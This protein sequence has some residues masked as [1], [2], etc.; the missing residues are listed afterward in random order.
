MNL[1]T[2]Q[3]QCPETGKRVH[4]CFQWAW[5]G[6]EYPIG[7]NHPAPSRFLSPSPLKLNDQSRVVGS[8]L[9]LTAELEAVE[10][11]VFVAR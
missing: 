3:C 11:D 10:I 6:L 9:E 5:E 8:G 7:T 2:C 4:H 1:A